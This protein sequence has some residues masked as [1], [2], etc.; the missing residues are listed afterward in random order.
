M[1]YFDSSFLILMQ[2]LVQSIDSSIPIVFRIMLNYL[3]LEFPGNKGFLNISSAKMH[4]IDH[5]SIA[6]V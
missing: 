3:K 2:N 6:V 4:P 5:K 1:D